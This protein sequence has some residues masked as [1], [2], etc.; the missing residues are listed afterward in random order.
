MVLRLIERSQHYASLIRWHQPTGSLLL[1]WPTLTALWIAANGK[2]SPQHIIIFILGV[3]IARSAGCIVNDLTDRNKDQFVARTKKR[4]LATKSISVTEALVVLFILSLCALGL[5]LLLNTFAFVLAVIAASLT[6]V[7]P[8]MKRVIDYPQVVLA[9]VFNFGV[10]IAFAAERQALPLVAWLIFA[11]QFVMT[12]AYDTEYAMADA[13]DDI[14]I[15]I[16]SSALSLA[17]SARSF[18]ICLQVL[19]LLL[20]L[21]ICLTMRFSIYVYA[22]LAIAVVLF[23]W[24]ALLIKIDQERNGF[25]AFANN[26]WVLLWIFLGVFLHYASL[27]L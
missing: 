5:V 22:S 27:S 9:V 11:S 24:Q 6:I 21:F 4:P 19:F 7:Y 13:S 20:W 15:G 3:F 8:W 10:L 26:Q 16:K 2:P 1:L 14:A 17:H 23:L 18:V 25:K 12:V